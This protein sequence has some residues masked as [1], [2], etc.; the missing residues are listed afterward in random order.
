[1]ETPCPRA[2][3]NN[4]ARAARAALRKMRAAAPEISA[5][6]PTGG[7]GAANGAIRN[8]LRGST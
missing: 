3:A 5:A 1:M 8:G 4:L 7:E 2:A 6:L